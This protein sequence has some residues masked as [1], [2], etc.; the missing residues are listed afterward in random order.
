[1]EQDK[2]ISVIVPVYN[3]EQYVEQTI[4][5]IIGQDIGFSEHVLLYLIDDGST[6]GSGEIC[7]K[8]ARQ[9]PG[10]IFY[11]RKANGGVSSARNVGISLAKTRYLNFCDADDYWGPEAFSRM[12]GFFDQHYDEIDMVASRIQVFGDVDY[13]HALNFRCTGNR[14]IDLKR[15]PQSVQT[16]VTSVIYKT[17]A[18]KA[19]SFDEDVN[20]LED[21]LF[22]TKLLLKK[23][24]YGI[25]SDT[26]FF[27]RR[28]FQTATLSNQVRHDRNW[29]L[30]V[31][32]KVFFSLIAYSHKLYG[33]TDEYVQSV[34][35]FFLRW[36][37]QPTGIE[38]TLTE[39]EQREYE[40]MIRSL[41]QEIS[42]DVLASVRGMTVTNR[43]F[44]FRLKY[45]VDIFS[46]ADCRNG[47]FRF[48]GHN[49]F[50]AKGRGVV[51]ITGAR[52]SKR[53]IAVSGTTLIGIADGHCTLH[54]ETLLGDE[55]NVTITD[56]PSNDV[57]AFNGDCIRR[58]KAFEV[59]V[60]RKWKGRFRMYTKT[61]R[62][63]QK[64]YC[65]PVFA[66]D[67]IGTFDPQIKEISIRQ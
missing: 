43:N 52:V 4:K 63:E 31:P 61:D 45:G 46:E 47:V 10:N 48:H 57:Y 28:Q 21:V 26:R 54:A 41:L 12:I 8:Y 5:S 7:E 29:Y 58:G 33:R 59:F 25:T 60:P 65:T 44:L 16:Y 19:F 42:D 40:T 15:E 14:I 32:E 17:D 50:S 18:I 22:N 27:Y 55:L 23:K 51:K 11:V 2:L 62:G 38:E 6:D 56:D 67:D 39:E 13:D 3:A 53:G 49:I 64:Y 37:V 66:A 34:I 35:A 20:L 9:Y 1:M 30:G 24:T 36:R